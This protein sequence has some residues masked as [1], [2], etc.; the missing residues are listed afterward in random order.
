MKILV[1]TDKNYPTSQRINTNHIQKI[2]KVN[3]GLE[4]VLLEN[5][6]D[7]LYKK[8]LA[9]AEILIPTVK[10]PE[11]VVSSGVSWIHVTSAGL[12]RYLKN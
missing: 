12:I 10:I 1:V 3:K 6:A 4:V 5:S 8:E 2:R 9:G 7:A 11:L